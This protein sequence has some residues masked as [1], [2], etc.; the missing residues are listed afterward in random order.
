M[1]TVTIFQCLLKSTRGSDLIRWIKCLAMNIRS[2]DTPP[3]SATLNWD[4]KWKGYESP[5]E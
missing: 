5:I 1:L 2:E 4:A 3:I